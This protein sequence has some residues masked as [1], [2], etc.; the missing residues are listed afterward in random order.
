MASGDCF[1]KKTHRRREGEEKGEER[2]GTER[3]PRGGE[4]RLGEGPGGLGQSMVRVREQD[5]A[6]ECRDISVKVLLLISLVVLSFHINIRDILVQNYFSIWQRN[7][8]N[9]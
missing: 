1:G 5:A 2:G 6:G 7:L 9:G 3:L 8:N 4:G